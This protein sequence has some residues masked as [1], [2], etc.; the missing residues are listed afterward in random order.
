MNRRKFLV[1]A[2]GA[3]FVLSGCQAP[4][5]GPGSASKPN[6][7][8]VMTDDQGY[9][10]V[11]YD[12]DT[13]VKTPMLDEMAEN[14]IR[15]ENAYSTASICTPT[16]AS[17]LTGRH[18]YRMGAFKHGHT[19]PPTEETIA[20]ICNEAGYKTGFFG[21]W[22]LGALTETSDRS[23]GAAGFDTWAASPNYYDR[24]P[25]L[26]VNGEATQFD[27][28]SSKVTFELAREFI[29]DAARN[30][31][32]FLA[33]IWTA[34][35]HRPYE[36]PAELESLY[37]N[38]QYQGYYGEITATDRAIGR[39]RNGLRSLGVAE[40]TMLWFTSDNG[41]SKARMAEA[42]ELRGA[43]NTLYEGGI[44]VPA[45]IEWPDKLPGGKQTDFT[46]TTTDIVP[47]I[48]GI[49]AKDWDPSRPM[50]GTDLS[51]LL[52]KGQSERQ[53]PIGYWKI[54]DMEGQLI[55]SDE[56]MNAMAEA[57]SRGEQFDSPY[58]VR[59]RR[60][61]TEALGRYHGEGWIGPAAW[62]QD[63]WKLH[64]RKANL[65]LY[66]LASDPGEQQNLIDAYPEQ[67]RE[68][69]SRLEKWK[70]SIISSMQSTLE[71]I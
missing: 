14:G 60:V 10:D 49:V 58:E 8:I 11:G 48:A 57:Q 54:T 47:T 59:T 61:L 12:S 24:D 42:Y 66:H 28:E 26:S 45:I 29:A 44:R 65:E 27:G 19:L 46:I 22:H 62:I 9:K 50:D 25:V 39:L 36:V 55:Y 68:M 1:G 63:D 32:P 43:K 33:V 56:I 70:E 20:D 69:N 31:D 38:N 4:K 17:F 16:R 7:V 3:G 71:A 15:F 40:D 51:G 2:T 37:E 6:I 41:A 13:P 23:P 35:P 34:N 53:T 18:A 21:K 67:A 5:N 64:V 52:D 30:D